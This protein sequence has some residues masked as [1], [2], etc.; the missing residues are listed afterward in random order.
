MRD[1]RYKITIWKEAAILLSIV[2]AFMAAACISKIET[3][4]RRPAVFASTIVIS[5]IVFI[6][7]IVQ[8]LTYLQD[9]RKHKRKW[10]KALF[11]TV[12]FII[13]CRLPQMG[14]MPRWDARTYYAMLRQAC[15]NYDFSIS[16]LVKGFSLAN[17]P[18][19]GYAGILAIGEFLL[20]G[21]YIGLMIVNLILAAGTGYCLYQIL[22]KIVP[23]ADWK[24]YTLATCTVMSAPLILGT[25]SYF[26]PDAGTVYFFIITVYCYLYGKNLLLMFFLCMLALSKEVGC[27]AVAFFVFGAFL[28]SIL[29]RGDKTI[30]G[31]ISG[32]FKQPLGILSIAG[33]LLVLVYLISFLKSGGNIWNIQSDT[34]AGFSTFSF[35]SEFILFKL[36]QYFLLNFNWLIWGT[37]I[38]LFI[39]SIFSKSKNA[40]WKLTRYIILSVWVSLVVFYS[41][42]ITFVLPRYHVLIDTLGVM[43]MLIQL[44]SV[45]TGKAAK[46][47]TGAIGILLLIQSY[48]TVDPVSLAVFENYTTGNGRIIA[49]NLND[50]TRQ[51]D[52]AVY[53]HQFNY[54]DAA[55][56][57]VLRDV[58][59]DGMMDIIAW[60]PTID[61]EIGGRKGIHMQNFWDTEKQ[62]YSLIENENTISISVRSKEEME[63]IPIEERKKEAI[64]VHTQQ[65]GVNQEYAER[66]INQ[67]YDIRYQGTVVSSWGG[68]VIYYVCDLKNSTAPIS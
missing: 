23:G 35:Q 37:N 32:F 22:E 60:E 9:I 68:T 27:V 34:I 13:V 33:G 40:D 56:E 59:Y 62:E 43:L 26:Q 66:Y 17:H 61:S 4:Y 50:G 3:A 1:I 53:N 19:L 49:E 15:E 20:P 51:R 10:N 48:Y 63:E 21:Q 41:S 42:Y 39:G 11:F 45:N 12:G 28:Y 6:F 38:I 31:A 2:N 16:Q 65:Y 47:F 36:R 67:D 44:G 14:D 57:Q 25:F 58:E 55:Y 46:L 5:S 52:Y 18:T 64:Y 54:M 30:V 24:F 8:I 29:N 7:W